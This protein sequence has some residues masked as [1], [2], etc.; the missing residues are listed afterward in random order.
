M[1]HAL[2]ATLF[3][4]AACSSPETIAVDAPERSANYQQLDTWF[5]APADVPL[6]AN[7]GDL[8]RDLLT[9]PDGPS[10]LRALGDAHDTVAFDV[11]RGRVYYIYPRYAG[12]S[13]LATILGP[14]FIGNA[15]FPQFL[16]LEALELGEDTL[17]IHYRASSDEGHALMLEQLGLEP[18]AHYE[19]VVPTPDG[20]DRQITFDELGIDMT[21]GR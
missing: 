21:L 6:D 11:D 2:S 10:E 7:Y 1:R 3:F 15:G 12:R 20:L 19:C 8:V 16:G 9:S 18:G 5:S 14:K 13:G 4:V 17:T